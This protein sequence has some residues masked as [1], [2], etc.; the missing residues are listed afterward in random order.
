M[1]T[2]SAD[3]MA[4]SVPAPMADGDAHVGLHQ[5]RGVIDAVAYHRDP[6]TVALELPDSLRL[7][8]GQYL[9]TILG[10]ANLLRNSP[11]GAGVVTGQH[12]RLQ[13]QL[14]HAL[15]RLAGVGLDLVG[16]WNEG[17]RG[18]AHSQNDHGIAIRLQLLNP[19]ADRAEIYPLALHESGA[20]NGDRTFFHL[21]RNALARRGL[22]VPHLGQQ[23]IWLC[24]RKRWLLRRLTK[25]RLLTQLEKRH[26]GVGQCRWS[27]LV[28]S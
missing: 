13:A 23:K 26:R 8:L 25:G 19:P 14:P 6:I 1:S 24:S 5:G 12:H 2:T 18:P 9:G 3:S 7:I 17:R 10:N 15:D 27:L 21:G 22:K 11:S 20:P 16:D 28:P 4:M